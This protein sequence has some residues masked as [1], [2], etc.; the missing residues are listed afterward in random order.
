MKI[1]TTVGIIA[2]FLTFIAL[3]MVF[4]YAEIQQ[5]MLEVQ[6]IFYFHVSAAA[7]AYLAFFVTFVCSIGYLIK[8]SVRF[9][10]LAVSSAEIGVLLCS[11]ALFSGPIWAR[12]AWNTWWTWEARL[13]TTLLLWL[14]YVAYLILRFALTGEQ[15]NIFSAV[16]GVIAFVNVPLVYFSVRFWKGGQHPPGSISLEHTMFWTFLISL[17]AF[18]ATYVYL[19]LVRSNIESMTNELEE[20]RI[21]IREAQID[22]GERL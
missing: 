7:T 22:T 13:T 14:M 8:R 6:K 17:L 10:T 19:L 5:T 2:C 18:I 15:K 16:F 1:Q 9:D 12:Y 20:L 11:I 4:C 3:Y 21:E